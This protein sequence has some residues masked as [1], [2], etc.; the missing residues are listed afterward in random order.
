M[1]E[2]GT[3]GT[4]YRTQLSLSNVLNIYVFIYLSRFQFPKEE[5]QDGKAYYKLA[6]LPNSRLPIVC[7]NPSTY[8]ND[9][10]KPISNNQLYENVWYV[11]KESFQACKVGSPKDNE[12]NGIWLSCDNPSVLNFDVLVFQTFSAHSKLSFPP[13]TMHYFVGK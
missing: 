8:L 9:M 12:I 3:A 13:G 5:I 10:E 4:N 11:D 7:P 2:V 1:V 6:V